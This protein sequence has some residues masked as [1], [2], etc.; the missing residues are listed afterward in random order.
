MKK[1]IYLCGMMLLSLNMMAQIDLNDRNWDID[2][3]FIDEFN[4][5]RTWDT[6]SWLSLPDE[7]WKA[8][9]G[10]VTH[11]RETQIYQYDHCQFDAANGVIRLVSEFDYD[12]LIPYHEYHLPNGQ[13]TYPN[14][15]NHY[16]T[17]YYF[18]GEMV[19]NSQKF[20]Y[21]YFEIRCKLP[22]HKGTF[23]AFWLH[24]SSKTL[25]DRYYEE[26]DIFEHSRNLLHS[27]PYWPGYIPPPLSDSARV[28]TTGL[29]HNLTG[30]SANQYEGSFARNFPLVPSTSN[31]LS[32]WHTFSCEWMPDHVFW[33]FDGDLVNS[34]FNQEHIPS[35][36]LTLII[37]YAI[38]RYA[39]KNHTDIPLWF[40]SNEMV[41]EYIHVYQLKW[42]CNTDETITCQTDLDNFNY[43]VKKSISIT[44]TVGQPIVS[45]GDKVTFRV[46]NA[47]EITGSFQID[48]G[49]EFTIIQQDCPSNN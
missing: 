3:A 12:S 33:Y 38:D 7:V 13:H 39:I 16:D 24:G 9:Y 26:I 34:Y 14:T 20:S 5:N 19:V 8:Y 28:F 46:T 21:G 36:D 29:Y 11:G 44:S 25:P 48:N 41:I 45:S 23:P 6:N 43:A 2:H 17:L 31:D 30:E 42:N 40:G 10:K 15:L 22:Q 47:F 18:S 35:H 32:D 37:N 27:R 49:A 4:I 1:F